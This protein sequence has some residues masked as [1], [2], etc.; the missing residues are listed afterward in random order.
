MVVWMGALVSE[1]QNL[2]VQVVIKL[3]DRRPVADSVKNNKDEI[4]MLG[5]DHCFEKQTNK[6]F[7]W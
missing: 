7:S 1:Q 5:E 6:F 4:R 2:W 3:P